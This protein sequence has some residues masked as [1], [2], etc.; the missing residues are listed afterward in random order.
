MNPSAE[1][2]ALK[3]V[4]ETELYDVLGVQVNAK[5]AEIKKA[6]YVKARESHPDR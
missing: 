5:P 6:Y 2:S 3:T 1:E 4:S